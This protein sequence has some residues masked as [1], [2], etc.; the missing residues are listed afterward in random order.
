[1]PDRG[2]EP[3][4]AREGTNHD[5]TER[6]F[7][8]RGVEP[9]VT[10]AA[11]GES[12]APPAE[13]GPISVDIG[14]LAQL[15]SIAT[16]HGRECGMSDTAVGDLIMVA[17][18]LAT[19][20]VRHGGGTGQMSFWR[21]DRLLYCQVSDRGPGMINPSSAGAER[22]ELTSLTGRGI[23]LIRQVADQMRIDAGTHGT[24]ITVA[25]AID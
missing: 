21:Q 1:M 17:N 3:G 19:N 7:G 8:D 22:I 6:S 14:S 23:W 15:R 25:L 20:A 5:R 11:S 10:G 16:D 24:T 9:M 13:V 4:A 2:R 18:E 12:G